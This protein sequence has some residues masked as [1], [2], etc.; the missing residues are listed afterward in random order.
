MNILK[1]SVLYRISSVLLFMFALGHTIGFRQIDPKW[2]VGSLLDSIRT[3]RFD[4][5]GF[6]R[7]WWEFYVG[8]GLLFTVFQVFAAI[9]CWQISGFSSEQLALIDRTRWLLALSFMVVTILC[10]RYFFIVPLV[11]STLITACLL[12]AAWLSPG[13]G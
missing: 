2:G 10:W 4:V 7:T 13:T 11:F 3:V 12:L 1:T 8:F 6:S 9:L 5:Q